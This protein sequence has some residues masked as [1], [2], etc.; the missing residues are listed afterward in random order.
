MRFN[1]K[2]FDSGGYHIQEIFRVVKRPLGEA[3]GVYTMIEM[4]N[5]QAISKGSNA[6]G[7]TQKGRA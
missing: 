4:N 6:L 7:I 2:F 5:K 1:V 3:E